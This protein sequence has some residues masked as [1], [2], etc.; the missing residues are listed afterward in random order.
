MQGNIPTL[1][2]VGSQS[3]V[4]A[5]AGSDGAPKPLLACSHLGKATGARLVTSWRILVEYSSLCRQDGLKPGRDARGRTGCPTEP[6]PALESRGTHNTQGP[7]T[8]TL[9]SSCC[10]EHNPEKAGAGLGWWITAPIP[11]G[12]R[13]HPQ[14]VSSGPAATANTN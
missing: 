2:P 9:F 1:T 3:C 5:R 6:W 11:M 14:F 7:S 12:D 13:I 4:S 10:G 8:L